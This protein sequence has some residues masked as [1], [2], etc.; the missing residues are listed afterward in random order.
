MKHTP[1]RITVTAIMSALI[2]VLSQVT[3]PLPS[4]IPITLQTF[5]VALCG[6]ML[7]RKYCILP[8][9]IYILLG[10]VGLPV[11]SGAQGG[12]GV[13]FSVTGG[14]I[15]G[16]L[17]LAFLC[18]AANTKKAPLALTCGA[19]GVIICHT[20]GTVHYSF[21]SGTALSAAFIGSSL[22]FLLKDLLSITAAYYFAGIINKR[23]SHYK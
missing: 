18:G 13:L 12:I 19:L 15:Y 5:A 6:Y 3:L 20:L 7:P 17:P 8:I 10:A 22:P 11:F 9:C 21:V 1:H 14:F 2:I 23:I 4:G 16:F